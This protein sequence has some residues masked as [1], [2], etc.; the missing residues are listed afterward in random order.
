VPVAAAI[1]E[2]AGP[3]AISATPATGREASAIHL[4]S[5]VVDTSVVIQP[6]QQN[7]PLCIGSSQLSR[8]CKGQQVIP[9]TVFAAVGFNLPQ[10]NAF[11]DILLNLG[12]R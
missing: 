5:G 9:E 8:A 1:D 11:S 12:E 2:Q 3:A 10:L 6:L 7:I 4:G